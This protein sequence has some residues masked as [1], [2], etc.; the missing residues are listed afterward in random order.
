MKNKIKNAIIILGVMGA[1]VVAVMTPPFNVKTSSYSGSLSV[2]NANGIV[3][4]SDGLLTY[5]D[6]NGFLESEEIQALNTL[7][8]QY[9]IEYIV[10][11]DELT[12]D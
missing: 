4:I 12:F 9:V 1:F 10:L 3:T 5:E 8:E 6:Y 11:F 7:S 2:L